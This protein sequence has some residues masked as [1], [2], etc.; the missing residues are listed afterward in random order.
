MRGHTT[1]IDQ[2]GTIIEKEECLDGVKRMKSESRSASNRVEL[3]RTKRSNRNKRPNEPARLDKQ[4]RN[5][6]TATDSER[7]SERQRRTE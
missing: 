1:T 7:A 6:R 4:E 3:T 2:C 5:D